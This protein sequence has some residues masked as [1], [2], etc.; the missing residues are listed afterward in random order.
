MEPTKQAF[1]DHGQKES[2]ANSFTLGKAK[3]TALERP[4]QNVMFP[5]NK[6]TLSFIVAFYLLGPVSETGTG[7]WFKILCCCMCK[8]KCTEVVIYAVKAS[9]PLRGKQTF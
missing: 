3:R 5:P 7:S 6:D 9:I 2:F 8:L 4:H 1:L